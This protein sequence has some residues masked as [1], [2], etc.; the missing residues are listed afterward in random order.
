MEDRRQRDRYSGKATRGWPQ[1]HTTN[2][3]S[4]LYAVS[5]CTIVPCFLRE[6]FLDSPP[7]GPAEVD[8][9]ATTRTYDRVLGDLAPPKSAKSRVYSELL[10]EHGTQVLLLVRSGIESNA[11]MH[12]HASHGM[13]CRDVQ[14]FCAFLKV[15]SVALRSFLKRSTRPRLIS[16]ESYG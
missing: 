1:S 14:S 13:C 4:Y 5:T 15:A 2:G 9:H 12:I 7:N 8:P 3:S 6:S 11:F 16:K 10:S